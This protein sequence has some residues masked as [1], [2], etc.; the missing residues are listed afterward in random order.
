MRTVARWMLAI[1]MVFAG[2]MHLTVARKE[3]RAQ[4][5][6]WVA[7]LTP[8]DE[9][10][11][12]V[13]SGVVEIMLGTALVALPR[14]RRRVGAILAAF[15]VAIFPGNLSQ[16][17]ERR[18]GFGLDTDTKRFVRLFFQPVLVIAAIWSTRD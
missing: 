16:Y 10:V 1:G 14:E 15:F 8:L 4:V 13:G 3:F 6:P 11:V 17:I 9:D 18:D 2:V 7:E 12:V 5:P